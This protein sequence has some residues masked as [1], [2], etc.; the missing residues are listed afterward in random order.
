MIL[1]IQFDGGLNAKVYARPMA[2]QLAI[3]RAPIR[4]YLRIHGARQSDDPD[5]RMKR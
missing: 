3:Q 5:I 1:A 4:A 2:L